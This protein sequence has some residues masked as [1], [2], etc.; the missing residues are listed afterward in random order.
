MSLQS[1]F[2]E[3]EAPMPD[4]PGRLGGPGGLSSEAAEQLRA[5]AYE[6]GYA[7]GWE[8]AARATEER[9]ARIDAEFERCVQDLGFTFHEAVTQLRG[10]LAV[11]LDALVEQFFPAML[12]TL[13]RETAREEIAR[14][15]EGLLDPKIEIVAA[16]ET[17]E[18]LRDLAAEHGGDIE[19][20]EEPSLGANQAF[21]RIGGREVA[22]DFA[23]LVATLREQLAALKQNA[24]KKV[25]NG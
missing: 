4:A 23:P 6:A 21:V 3:F 5:R 18:V 24:G 11:L 14:M 15:A 8:D 20:F 13:L 7:S 17:L 12:P 22:I 1:I 16:G 19:F 2:E 25:S 10:E 9:T